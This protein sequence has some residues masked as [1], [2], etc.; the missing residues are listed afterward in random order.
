LN[1]IEDTRPPEQSAREVSLL[2]LLQRVWTYSITTKSDYARHYADEIAE[3][4]SRGFLT[5]LV[6]PGRPIHG[7]LWKM[8]PAGVDYLFAF[9]GTIADEEVTNYAQAYCAD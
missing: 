6:V 4:S 2:C 7:R 1:T 5:T 3:A 8:T 9:A